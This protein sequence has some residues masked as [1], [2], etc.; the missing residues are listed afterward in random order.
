MLTKYILTIGGVEHE[1]PDECLK[2]WDEIAFS[3]KRTDYSGVMRSFSTQFVFV[4]EMKDLLWQAYLADGFL[5]SASIAVYTITDRHLWELQFSSPLDFS[6]VETEE[7]TLTINAMDNALASLLKSKKSQK[8]EFEVDTFDT[9]EVTLNRVDLQNFA[10]YTFTDNRMNFL[11][12]LNYN[13]SESQIISSEYFEPHGQSG[14]GSSTGFATTKKRGAPLKVRLR[15]YLK[16]WFCPYKKIGGMSATEDVPVSSVGIFANNQPGQESSD[17]FVRIASFYPDDDIMHKTIHGTRVAMMVNTTKAS[18]FATLAALKAAAVER[19]GND[20]VISSDYNGIFGVVGTSMDVSSQTYWQGNKIWEFGSGTWFDKGAPEDYHQLRRIDATLTIPVGSLYVDSELMLSAYPEASG[21]LILQNG[22]FD[23]QWND[24]SREPT[25]CRAIKPLDL[26]TRIVRSITGEE[27]VV[28]IAEEPDTESAGDS[29]LAR[30]LIL[31]GEE[32]RKITGSKIYTTFGEFANW[33]SA[34]FGYTY[35]IDGDVLQFVHRS[36]VFADEV[37]KDIDNYQGFKFAI[38]DDLIYTSVEAGYAKKEYGEIDGRLEKNFTN[39]Y[40]TEFSLT[41]KKLSLM[42]KY[43]ADTYGIEFTV[44]K[45]ESEEESETKDDKAD[46]AVFFICMS[47]EDS[48]MFSP[49]D[50]DAFNPSQCVAKNRGFIAV[51]AAGKAMTL[52]MTSSDGNNALED[53]EIAAGEALFTAAEITFTTDDM[54]MPDDINAMVR[55]EH[56][57]YRYTGFIK[58]AEAR[59]GRENGVEYTL[60]VKS[61]TEI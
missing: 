17:V 44:R 5:A 12:K 3:L 32:L 22:A 14:S 4:G 16:C 25:T 53:V 48:D 40:S 61:I 35:R 19:Y 56:D 11:A 54:E 29:A 51:P 37:V 24:P 46:E 23:I 10:K 38:V 55:L 45:S 30:T 60:I 36:E 13:S 7:G 57:G 42:S 21:T 47:D 1:V 20:G 27:T 26:V 8:Y 28:D 6:T 49:A 2:N 43:R 18:V 33:M 15:G 41:D 34:V 50:N 9:T 58:E 39:Y 59:Y 31:A 52:T